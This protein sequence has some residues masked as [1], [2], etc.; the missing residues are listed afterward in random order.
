MVTKS[1]EKQPIEA[2]P[3]TGQVDPDLLKRLFKCSD[4]VDP[5]STEMSPSFE[6]VPTI[7]PTVNWALQGG[8]VPGRFYM[9]FGPESSGKSMFVVSQC[10]EYLKKYPDKVIVWFDAEESF[11]RH[12]VNIFMSDERGFTEFDREKRLIVKKVSYGRDVF[13]FFSKELVGMHDDGLKIGA[14]VLDSVQALIPPKE[15]NRDNTEK[16]LIGALSGYLPGA[17]RDILHSAR[18][19]DIS[20]FFISQV[21]DVMDEIQ[22]RLGQKFSF[23]GG[24]SFLHSIDAILLFE[25]MQGK[26]NKIFHNE[27]KG[28]DGN[29]IQIGHFIKMKVLGKCRVGVPNRVAIFKFI[30]EKGI[31]DTYEEIAKLALG[32]GVVNLQ[33]KTYFFGKDKIGVGERDYWKTVRES[34]ELQEQLCKLIL[35]DE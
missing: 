16:A 23:S 30:Y 11:T 18:E 28:P 2:Q 15:E 32:L 27:K 21:R 8:M 12:W 33:G 6:R 29:F 35:E 5:K 24:K 17:L 25:Q 4:I 34:T 13:D 10:A 31:V 19:R 20:W 26:S 3:V 7:S 14:C 22:K 9:M 1:K